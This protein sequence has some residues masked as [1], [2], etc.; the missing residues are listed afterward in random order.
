MHALMTC[1][2]NEGPFL[3]EFVAHHLVLGF[4]RIMMASNDCTDGTDDLLAAL[5]Q[6]GY[7]QHLDQQLG[8]KEIPQHAGY[9]KLRAQFGLDGVTW[10]AVLDVDEFLH[11]SLP[12]GKVQDLTQR[13]PNDVDIIALN[14]LTYGT[15]LGGTWQPGRVCAQFTYRFGK[16]QGR[17]GA[18]KSLT[19]DPQRFRG[20]HNHHMI[21][22]TQA[23]PL[24]AM[25]GDG[26]VFDIDLETPIWRQLRVKRPTVTCHDWAHYNHYAVKTY[27]SFALRRARGRGARAAGESENL[28]HNDDYFATHIGASVFD[29]SISVYAPAVEAKMAQILAHPAIA[30]AQA[31]SEALYGAMVAQLRENL[32]FG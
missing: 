20:N 31:K 32:D 29:D 5:H 28:R 6:E 25:R 24:R 17:N 23:G 10:L 11:V 2:K 8:P 27:D 7:V 18:L 30:Q 12:S 1:V 13:A 3:L 4:D 19:R 15:D 22:F 21:G 26:S 16:R 9:A 14:A